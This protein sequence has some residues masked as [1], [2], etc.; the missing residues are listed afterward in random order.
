MLAAHFVNRAT[1]RAVF[2]CNSAALGKSKIYKELL[3]SEYENSAKE[4]LER[5]LT[6]ES[7]QY[8]LDNQK[9]RLDTW[10]DA[11]DNLWNANHLK[12][13]SLM[14]LSIPDVIK[15]REVANNCFHSEKKG[16]GSMLD[17]NKQVWSFQ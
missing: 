5:G 14:P 2:H 15:V 4:M 8:N 16:F 3:S 7:I 12:T 17:A 9:R 11:P 10:L 13:S 6:P 1:G